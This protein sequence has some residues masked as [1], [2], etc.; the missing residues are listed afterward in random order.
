MMLKVKKID[1]AVCEASEVAPKCKICTLNCTLQEIA[2]LN[3]LREHPKVTP[4]RHYGK[5]QRGY[6]GIKPQYPRCVVYSCR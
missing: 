5:R 3:F 1:A 6:C 2:V 4:N